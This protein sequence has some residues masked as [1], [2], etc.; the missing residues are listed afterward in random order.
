M[1]A[2]PADFLERAGE[3]LEAEELTPDEVMLDDGDVDEVDEAAVVLEEDVAE[4]AGRGGRGSRS[5]RDG[6]A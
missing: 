5:G 1:V 3:Y 2:P 6:D 4:T